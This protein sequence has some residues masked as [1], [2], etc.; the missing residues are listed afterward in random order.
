MA[1]DIPVAAWAPRGSDAAVQ[2]IVDTLAAHPGAP[3]VL[4]ANH[5][6]LAFGADILAVAGL[7]LAMEEAAEATLR[8]AAIG[9]A[10]PFPPGALAEV[11]AAGALRGPWRRI[12]GPAGTIDPGGRDRC[13][14]MRASADRGREEPRVT[15]RRP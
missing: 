11:R 13:G 8:A 4:L 3:A 14:R 2:A 6:L 12:C 15:R 7:V 1:A 5:G 10:Q 9:G